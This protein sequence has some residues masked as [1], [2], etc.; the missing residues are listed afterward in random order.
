MRNRGST[1]LLYRGRSGVFALLIVAAGCA[2]DTPTQTPTCNFVQIQ[3]A[4]ASI[5]VGQTLD[6][7]GTVFKTDSTGACVGA[8][9]QPLDWA[10]DTTRLTI[11]TPATG[12]GTITVRGKA[13]GTAQITVSTSDSTLSGFGS[14]VVSRF[15]PASLAH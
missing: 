8:I 5:V 15:G 12:V 2:S 3:A 10:V 6:L 1:R 9:D 4:T 14:I 13:I 7:S 11:E